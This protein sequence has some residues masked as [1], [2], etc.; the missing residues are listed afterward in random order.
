MLIDFGSTRFYINDF[1]NNYRGCYHCNYI[2]NDYNKVFDLSRKMQ[3]PTGYVT[4]Q[5]ERAHMDAV[6]ILGE[7]LRCNEFDFGRQ[8]TTKE[9]A[10]LVRIMITHR[11]CPSPGERLHTSKIIGSI[12]AVR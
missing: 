2:D 1:I 9:I 10:T 7:M 11:L 6:M 12:F 3:F 5:M 4:K 8:N